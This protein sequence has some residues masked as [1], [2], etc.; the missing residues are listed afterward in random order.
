MKIAILTPTFFEYSGID[1]VAEQQAIDYSKKVNEVTVF[2]FQSSI[3]P[4]GYRVI[5]MGMPKSLFWQRI[6]RLLFFLDIMR[7][8]K[9]AK[10]LG[11][12]DMAVSHMYP[13]NL[14]A[15]KAKKLYNVR[16]VFHN[17]G[18]GYPKL[19]S[20]LPERLY[21]RLFIFFT[22]ISLNNVDEAVSISSFMQNELKRE[23]G[24]GSKVV[25]NRVDS[26]KFNKK[27]SGKEVRKKLHLGKA[28]VLLFVGRL[29]PHKG[30]DLL[31][32]AFTEIKKALPD[33]KLVI[34][35]K[36]TFEGYYASLKRIACRDVLFINSVADKILPKFY[37]ACDVYVT[38]SLWEGFDLPAAEAQACGKKVVA[39]DCCSHPEIVKRGIL[40]KERD[41]GAFADAVVRILKK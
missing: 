37:A 36:P 16:Y 4:R 40:V 15:K 20:T 10:M 33:A 29:S 9:Y 30:I 17:H 23:F 41:T 39:F 24:I 28:H 2:T 27:V 14:I 38:A 25:Y 6:Y 34:V 5:E 13:M 1:R 21:M 26:K 32:N 12:Y 7:I 19:F 22:G 31:L 8:G 18:I 11:G 35:G 3:K